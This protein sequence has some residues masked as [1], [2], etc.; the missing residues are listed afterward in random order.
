TLFTPGEGTRRPRRL[1]YVG[2]LHRYKGAHTLIEAAGRLRA[3]GR[4]VEVTLVGAGDATYT[5]ELRARAHHEGV[6]VRFAG[7]LPRSA[8]PAIYR[9]HDAFVFPSI[10]REPFGLTPLEA[11]ACG[12]PVIGTV[13]GG[14][15]EL[16]A[17]G[18]NAVTFA[19]GDAAA[20]VHAVTRLDDDGLRDAIVASAR[21]HVA[22]R[23]DLDG[24]VSEIERELVRAA[25]SS[26]ERGPTARRS[27]LYASE[28][29][30][31]AAMA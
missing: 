1:L 21:E 3:S 26:A 29:H 8:L 13:D 11:M 30:A 18:V 24:Y 10:W 22:Q 27:D 31:H 5:A 28:R 9:A 15:G 17:D 7:H 19:A 6:D 20:L 25:G 2:Q 12:V 14:Q 16:L 23:H 4:E